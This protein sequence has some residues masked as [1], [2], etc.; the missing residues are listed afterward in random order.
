MMPV[1]SHAPT[2]MSTSVWPKAFVVPAPQAPQQAWE[3]SA[4]ALFPN[5]KDRLLATPQDPIVHAEG[6]VWTHTCMVIDALLN[7]P[8]Y[9][10]LNDA[11]R[12][13]V[14]YAAL[15]HDIAKPETTKQVGDK[16]T[17]PGHSAKGAIATRIALWEHLVPFDLREH[18]CRLIEAHQIPFFAMDS[19]R[20]LPPEATARQLACDRRIDLLCLLATADIKGRVCPDQRKVL[21]DIALFR[22]QA[23]ELGCLKTPYAF[24]DAA[25][26]VAYLRAP[27][28]RHADEPVFIA[29]PCQVVMMSGLPASGKNTWVADNAK[30][31]P[32]VSYDDI[33]ADLGFKHGD[34]TGT[35]VHAADDAM[36]VHLR[37]GTPFVVNATNLSRQMRQRTLDRIHGY[38]AQTTIVYCESPK[39]EI[40]RRNQKRDTTLTNAKLLHMLSRWETPSQSEAEH[41]QVVLTTAAP[42]PRRHP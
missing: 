33:R 42:R 8:E 1:C 3:A 16:V 5:L 28:K 7:E 39:D 21:D 23:L 19:R 22:E 34:G 13:V 24:P 29:K 6:D 30:G 15:L 4:R 20:A 14:F 9:A 10:T 27:T 11:E 25:T 35:I 38:G 32:V 17:A 18:V 26:K 36:R 40:L 2:L 31:W 37:A 12:G 41:V